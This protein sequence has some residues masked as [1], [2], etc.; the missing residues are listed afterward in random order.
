MFSALK[1]LFGKSPPGADVIVPRI[2]H[3]NFLRVASDLNIPEEQM[4]VTQPL[5]ADLLVAYAFDRPDTFQMVSY[6]DLDRLGLTLEQLADVAKENLG[7]RGFEVEIQGADAFQ[8]LVTGGHLEACSLLF[9]EI[10]ERITEEF[11]G[12]LV[13]AVPSR[14]SVLITRRTSKAGM[15]TVPLLAEE[16]HRSE[17]V[18][19]LSL[20]LL[21]WAGTHW[22]IFSAPATDQTD[23]QG[24]V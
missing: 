21:S 1:R 12:G 8:V 13:V 17:T 22:E 9:P 11:G 19:A 2:K 14:D 7:N 15:L 5:Q 23:S 16:I 18:H 3:L 4:P 24:P 6:A 20:A 10:W